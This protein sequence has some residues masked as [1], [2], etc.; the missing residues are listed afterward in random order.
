VK[1]SKVI[2]IR[3]SRVGKHPPAGFL[4]NNPGNIRRTDP[5]EP[6]QGRTPDYLC[7]QTAY[8]EFTNPIWGVRAIAVT[9]ITYQDKYNVRT[10]AS[11]VPRYAPEKDNNPTDEYIYNLKLWTGFEAKRILNAHDFNDLFPMVK[12]I[13]RQEIGNGPE[14]NGL[15]ISDAIIIEGLRRAGVVCNV[16]RKLSDTSTARTASMAG[17]GG[18]VLGTTAAVEYIKDAANDIKYSFDPSTAI[19]LL[20]SAL[21]VACCIYI[22]WKRSRRLELESG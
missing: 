8:E 6:W 21:V 4:R 2:P 12:G 17:I 22:V 19:Y 14:E 16:K 1:A 13:I 5:R 11:I 10:I 20:I 7:T 3:K 15:W 18:S 9:L